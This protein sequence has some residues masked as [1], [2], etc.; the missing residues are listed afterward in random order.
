MHVD[1]DKMPE[2][3]SHFKKINYQNG[4]LGDFP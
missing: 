1:L 2:I 4:C 3:H